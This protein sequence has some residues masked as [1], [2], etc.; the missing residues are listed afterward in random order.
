[1]Y[2][3]SHLL[4]AMTLLAPVS[5][6]AVQVDAHGQLT[7]A[8]GQALQLRGVTWP[9]FDRAALVAAGL[10]NSTLQ[11]TLDQMQAADINALRVPVC[12]ATLQ[13]KPVAA[14]D[15]AG[16]P[17]LRGLNSLQALDAVV[18]AS[19]QRGMQ[20]LLAF[21]DGGCDDSAPQLGAKQQP[22]QTA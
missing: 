6:L 10:R 16:E 15:V 8:R 3:R 9:G 11:Q 1:M 21:A 18:R 22:G 2:S 14:A 20:V 5:A 17:A 19:T 4:L 7:D 13:A 12:T